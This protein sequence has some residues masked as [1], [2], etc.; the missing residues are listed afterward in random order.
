MS[1]FQKL[2]MHHGIRL[3]KADALLVYSGKIAS[4][5]T[6]KEYGIQQ[7]GF[8]HAIQTSDEVNLI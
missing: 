2:S 1:G 4:T 6:E 3:P 7:V 8:S 5:R